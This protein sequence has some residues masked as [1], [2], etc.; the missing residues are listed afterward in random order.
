LNFRE[1]QIWLDAGAKIS[2]KKEAHFAKAKWGV[3]STNLLKIEF[4]DSLPF[5]FF[6]L[7]F[8]TFV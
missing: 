8:F 4:V 2:Q 3:E 7:C 1:S 5:S 6:F